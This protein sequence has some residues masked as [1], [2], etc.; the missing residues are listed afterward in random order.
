MFIGDP[1]LGEKLP[2]WGQRS[3]GCKIRLPETGRGWP[4]AD[5]KRPS[6]GSDH[7]WSAD[8][9]PH[10]NS[11]S[12]GHLGQARPQEP[13]ASLQGTHAHRSMPAPPS[14]PASPPLSSAGGS[15]QEG[16]RYEPSVGQIPPSG[17]EGLGGLR[18]EDSG[19]ISSSRCYKYVS[20]GANWR[21]A[22]NLGC[23]ETV[24]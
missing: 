11:A 20:I 4:L 21:A 19:F 15:G 3:K 8:A 10:R 1:G 2:V 22:G 7:L 14:C 13:G 12:L 6:L 24:I 5:Q 9:V 17:C 23:A 16:G 18:G